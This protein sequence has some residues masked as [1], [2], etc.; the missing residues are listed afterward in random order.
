MAL[1]LLPLIRINAPLA[2]IHRYVIISRSEGLIEMLFAFQLLCGNV[3]LF[4]IMKRAVKDFKC[5]GVF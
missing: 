3:P 5:V 1:S 4:E 2:A